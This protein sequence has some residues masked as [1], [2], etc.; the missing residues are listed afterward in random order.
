MTSEEQQVQQQREAVPEQATIVAV[1]DNPRRT[2]LQPTPQR[3]VDE[4]SSSDVSSH[5]ASCNAFF[6]P[7]F[8]FN[9]LRV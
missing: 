3:E 4:T 9:Y 2:Q 7:G 5:N 8:F 1:P 6:N